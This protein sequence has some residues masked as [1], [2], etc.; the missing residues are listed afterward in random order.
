MKNILAREGAMVANIEKALKEDKS[1]IY[2]VGKSHIENLNT[3]LTPLKAEGITLQVKDNTAN[4]HSGKGGGF[5]AKLDN[6]DDHS[7]HFH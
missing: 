3:A 6:N 1:V 2:V 4:Y 7:G 5:V